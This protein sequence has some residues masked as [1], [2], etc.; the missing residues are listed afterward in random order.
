MIPGCIATGVVESSVW[1][2]PVELSLWLNL[3]AV[4]PRDLYGLATSRPARRSGSLGA[5]SLTDAKE[6]MGQTRARLKFWTL[7]EVHHRAIAADQLPG[8]VDNCSR[9]LLEALVAVG[10]ESSDEETRGLMAI[11]ASPR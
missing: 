1:H 3:A 6:K 4:L 2:P 9:A 8:L 7:I 10:I 11:G 5:E